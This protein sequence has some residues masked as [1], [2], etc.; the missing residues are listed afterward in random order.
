MAK[1]ELCGYQS[2]PLSARFCESFGFTTLP[3]PP[4]GSPRGKALWNGLVPL[5]NTLC[6]FV[7]IFMGFREGFRLSF[8]TGHTLIQVSS[9]SVRGIAARYDETIKPG[10]GG[11]A[12][13]PRGNCA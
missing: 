6:T 8:L 11:F 4:P 2:P 7:L 9:S 13:L 10:T 5:L 1:I 3:G 12:I